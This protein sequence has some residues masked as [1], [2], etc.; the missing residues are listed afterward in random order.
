VALLPVAALYGISYAKASHADYMST[1]GYYTG[2]LTEAIARCRELGIDQVSC[3]YWLAY[4]FAFEAQENPIVYVGEGWDRYPPYREAWP[5]AERRAWLA[6]GKE[7]AMLAAAFRRRGIEVMVEE[8][9]E[10]RLFV[11]ENQ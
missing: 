9:G 7:K 10:L 3:S 4:R 11:P 1:P 8:L 2:P 6:W 5:E